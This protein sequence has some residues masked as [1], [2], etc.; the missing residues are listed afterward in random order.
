MNQHDSIIIYS[1]QTCYALLYGT[2][3]MT[4][5]YSKMQFWSWR[6]IPGLD[7]PTGPLVRPVRSKSVVS[8][9]IIRSPTPGN[10][11]HP[12]RIADGVWIEHAVGNSG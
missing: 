1:T 6:I 4:I 10:S 7:E 3:M 9:V 2:R 11:Y 5:L 8:N 12:R